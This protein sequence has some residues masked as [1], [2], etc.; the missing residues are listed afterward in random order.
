MISR[1]S[2]KFET[3]RRELILTLTSGAAAMAQ[4]GGIG[5]VWKYENG[6]A[7]VI[8]ANRA[9]GLCDVFA[10]TKKHW[11]ADTLLIRAFYKTTRDIGNAGNGR[12]PTALWLSDFTTAPYVGTEGYGG[13]DRLLRL[14]AKP[15]YVE[16]KI[17][18]TVG[19]AKVT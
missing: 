8:I 18:K 12:V 5:P 9:D 6:D 19:A 4:T 11:N 10:R 7:E 16:V 2:R 14:E 17:L 3:T 13:G 1:A 15:E